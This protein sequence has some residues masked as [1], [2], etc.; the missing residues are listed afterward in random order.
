MNPFDRAR[1]KAIETRAKLAGPLAS[2]LLTSTALL[3]R[4][5][6]IL[7]I[8]VDRVPFGHAALGGGNGVLKRDDETIS[9][10]NDASPAQTSYLIAHELG[11]WYL[12]PERPETTVSYLSSL[13]QSH[14]TLATVTVEAYGVH[15]RLELQANVF[16]RELLLPREVARHLW[17]IGQTASSIAEQLII[18]LELVRQQLLDALLLPAQEPELPSGLPEMSTAQRRAA[19]ADERF[20]NVI[21]GPGTGKTTTLVHRIKHLIEQGVRPNKILV[22]TFTNRAAYELVERLR[23][24][25]IN[26]A[27]DIWAGTFHSFGLEFLRK[28]HQLYNLNAEIRIADQLMQVRLLIRLLSEIDL[29]YYL[30][31][32]DPY[33]WIPDVLKHIQR[34]KEE[35]I[36]PDEYRA[37]LNGLPLCAPD[38]ANQRADIA[39][40]YSAYQAAMR[41]QK[42]VDYTDLLALP[43]ITAQNDRVAITQWIDHY[44][45]ILVDEY[46]D[47]TEV[48]V[49]LVRQ[50]AVKARSVWVVGDVRQAIHHWRGASIMSLVKFD[51]TFDRS[52]PGST[53]GTYPLDLNRRSTPEIVEL[54]SVAGRVHSLEKRMPLESVSAFRPSIRSKPVLFTCSSN[55]SQSSTLARNVGE[56]VRRGVPYRQQALISR[57]TAAIEQAAEDLTAS[58]IPCIYIGDI[59][60]RSEIKRL[61]C[62][63][64]LLCTRQPRSLIGLMQDPSFPMTFDD[65]Q[66]L[67]EAT[68]PGEGVKMQRGKWIGL[69]ILGLSNRGL[70]AKANLAELL[71]GFN[72]HANPWDFVCTLLLDRRYGLPSLEDQSIAAHTARLA[73]WLFVY[74]VRNGDGDASQARLSKFL[75][76]ED[77]RRRIGEKIGDRGLPPEAR[78]LDAVSLMTVHSSKGLEFDAIHVTEVEKGSYGDEKPFGYD[79][80]ISQLLPPEVLNST[81]EE[82]AFEEA[83]E[84]NNLL[85]VA[86]SRGRDYV[87][88]YELETRDRPLQLWRAHKLDKLKIKDGLPNQ[89]VAAHPVPFA[90]DAQIP[91]LSYSEF[92]T[93]IG[94]PL[95][96]HY[97]YELSLTA[98][99]EVDTSIRAR[100]AVMDTLQQT[101]SSDQTQWSGLFNDSWS[102]YN[103]PTAEEDPGL[104]ADATLA[105]QRGLN[106]MGSIEGSVVDNLEAE[107]GG[108]RIRL[109]WMLGV[110]TP[111]GLELHWLR[112][113]L[114]IERTLSHLRPMMLTMNG[115]KIS[116]ANVYS[117]ITDRSVSQNPS[118]SATA[119]TAYKMARRFACGDRS[120]SKGLMCKRCAYLSIC[121]NRP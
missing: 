38:V 111:S 33:D 69:P 60:Q 64:Q 8:A 12:D 107:V 42:L 116:R 62:L 82:H 70:F 91:S 71:D 93:Y 11:H 13:T 10:R 1:L 101:L 54:F 115:L 7:E 31:L 102:T 75:L 67:I 114:G 5:E 88:L 117:L 79:S 58:G 83:V 32:Q 63:M 109:P 43:A 103:L 37:R 81:S 98:E 104:V 59:Y 118:V 106:L 46:Q 34:L 14:G 66:L 78:A 112:A 120:A 80:R 50:L 73:L 65:M 121:D 44:E 99:Q 20:V 96:Y 27:S 24:S 90:K 113:Q 61:I 119:T 53:I 72:R 89:S 86:L 9:I 52:A 21:A 68:R 87:L 57:K 39:S 85:Y 30:R 94:C 29:Q 56:L 77:L 22:L 105:I 35:L 76:R 48:M 3:A 41:E 100:W 110:N 16:A 40:L 2:P 84:R 92:E 6:E 95:Q 49:E 74:A 26:G 51:K 36:S 15:E 4:I 55:S 23:A 47:V 97:R 19:T 45:H 18:P 108:I 17:A 25:G 28:Y